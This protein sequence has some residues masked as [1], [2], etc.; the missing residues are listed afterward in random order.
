MRHIAPDTACFPRICRSRGG[1]HRIDALGSP[2]NPN[3][4]GSGTILGC[5]GNSEIIDFSQINASKANF[6]DIYR[7]ADP[8]AYFSVLGA[9]D[10]MI[11]D[12]AEP[13]IRQILAAKA[14]VDGGAEP[15]VLD[16]GCSYGIN[17]ALHRFRLSFDMLR[18]RYARREMAALNS[19]TM[20]DLDRNYFASWPDT[21]QGHFIGLDASQPAIRY[22]KTVGLLD[23][24]VA[25]DLEKASLSP[26]QARVVG[27]A[28][29]IL[30]T[31]CV[32]YV[33]EKTYRNLLDAIDRTPWI[34]SFVLRLFPYEPLAS[35]FAERGL[36]TER[37]QG[38]TFVQRRFRDVEEFESTIATLKERGVDTAGFES[39]GLFHADLFLSR[40]EADAKALPLETLVT[41]TSGRNK[42]VGPRYV[43]V[44]ADHGTQVALVS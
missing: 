33:T 16:V 14:D 34:V 10:Y 42:T 35:V 31:G 20:I 8:R 38:A 32:G 7:M 15:V 36:V 29:V 26:E 30:A 22:A 17:A 27:R 25:I 5:N 39:E 21:G 13:V 23:D 41:V 24:G 1:H 43:T 6:D 3:N 44:D 40:P 37:L 9:L 2:F 28:N 19:D 18:R 4:R 12:V 11:P